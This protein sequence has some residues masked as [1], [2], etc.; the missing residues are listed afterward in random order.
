M[1]NSGKFVLV[2]ATLAIVSI[3]L[4]L[5]KQGRPTPVVRSDNISGL[6]PPKANIVTPFNLSKIVDQSDVIGVGNVLEV[7]DDRPRQVE[8]LHPYEATVRVDKVLKGSLPSTI[9]IKLIKKA[10]AVRNG[11]SITQSLYAMFFLKEESPKSY[12]LTDPTVEAL[13]ASDGVSGKEGDALARV[14]EVLAQVLRSNH[15]P[16]D[17]A[18]AIAALASVN[19][20]ASNDALRLVLK[21]SNEELK[22]Q[23][24][25]G[26][27]RHNDVSVLK[28]VEETLLKPTN[29]TNAAAIG[30][31]SFAI[32]LGVRDPSGIPILTRL[33]TSPNLEVRRAAAHGLRETRAPAA[34]APLAAALNDTDQMVR[35]D[36]ILGLSEITGDRSHAPSVDTFKRDEKKYL[37]YWQGKFPG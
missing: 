35:Y 2:C 27:L 10:N 30:H 11:K 8:I 33:L 19:S 18:E 34:V 32:Q 15:S 17:Q 24:E 5:L 20:Q 31:L 29:Q 28:L 16:A 36:A 4:L 6:A 23:A 1:T 22:L 12:T 13:V 25:V 21:S 14:I 3:S 26:L 9:K 37:A 7:S